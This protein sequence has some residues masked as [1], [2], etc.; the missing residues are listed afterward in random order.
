MS[1]EKCFAFETKS[2]Q[3]AVKRDGDLLALDFPSR[4]PLPTEIH[5]ALLPA[6]GGKPVEVLAARDY[7]V[8]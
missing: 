5:P 7:L 4:P 8:A 1:P 2:G 6:M 3:L